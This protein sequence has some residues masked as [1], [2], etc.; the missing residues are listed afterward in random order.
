MGSIKTARA[1]IN[2]ALSRINACFDRPYPRVRWNGTP[3]IDSSA[4]YFFK[5]YESYSPEVQWSVQAPGSQNLQP[6]THWGFLIS[7]RCIYVSRGREMLSFVNAF[8]SRLLVGPLV[9]WLRLTWFL[10]LWVLLELQE[11][12]KLFDEPKVA[13]LEIV[14][15]KRVTEDEAR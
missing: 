7:V 3:P 4:G 6:Q 10:F 9:G 2:G 13:E 1:H 14:L 11:F 5:Q 8:L 12:Y 15:R